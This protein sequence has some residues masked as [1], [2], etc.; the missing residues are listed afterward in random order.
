[1]HPSTTS[2]C[3]GVVMLGLVAT[4][5]PAALAQD[6]SPLAF[7]VASVRQSL[8]PTIPRGIDVFPGR[9]VSTDI[10]LRSLIGRAYGVPS[11]KIENAPDWVGKESFNVQAT[12]P[13]SSTP[14]DVNA[15]LRTLLEQRFRLVVEL[16]TRDM[17]TDVL[18]LANRDGPLGRGMHPVNVDCDAKQLREGSAPGLFPPEKRPPCRAFVVT[19]RLRLNDP[20]GIETSSTVRYAA[21]TLTDLADL[22]SGSHVRPVLNRTELP[23]QFDVELDYARQ[24]ALPAALDAGA[25]ASTPGGAPPLPQALEEQLGLR[26]RRERNL[27][28]VLIVRSAERPRPEED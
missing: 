22:L 25:A 11:W 1:M 21:V 27:V 7:E 8:V 10:P 6:R 24:Q 5:G 12:F 3:C 2:V 26:L 14:A 9:F 15:M 13:P 4:A 18:T 19:A 20:T 16:E 23:G 17:D 28:E